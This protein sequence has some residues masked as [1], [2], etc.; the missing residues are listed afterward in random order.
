MKELLT[1]LLFLLEKRDRFK[2][3][4]LLTFILSGTLFELLGFGS[5]LPFLYVVSKPEL[6][7]ENVFLRNFYAWISPGSVNEFLVWLGLLIIVVFVLK[8]S[9]LY[10]IQVS[11]IKFSTRT[12]HKLASRLFRSYLYNPYSFHL[13]RNS[14]QLL[15]NIGIVQSIIT[16]ILLPL[17]NIITDSLLI[18]SL[19]IL[20]FI[21][22]GTSSLI[23]FCF[24]GFI[25]FLYFS[26][27]KNKLRSFGEEQKLHNEMLIRQFNQGLGSIKESK[28]LGREHFFDKSYS[29]H[30]AGLNRI[31]TWQQSI[32]ALPHFII[33][34]LM[35]TLI[36][37][38]MFIAIYKGNEI[39]T[40]LISLSFF[41]LAA[42]RLMPSLNKVNSAVSMIRFYIPGLEEV[43]SDLK[44]SEGFSQ[45]VPLEEKD[46][47]II[48][49]K[50]LE[51]QHISFTY[52]GTEKSALEDINLTIPKNSTVGFVGKSGAGKT[53]TVD[54]ILGLLNPTKGKVL[55]DGSDIHGEIKSW[56]RKAGHVPQQ[57]YLMD[58]TITA[59][60][61]FGI[62]D[63]E[64]NL[65]KELAI[66]QQ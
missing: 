59:N 2:V 60:I 30:L 62:L 17:I 44:M 16:G 35:V 12:H 42:V 63:D 25:S 24:V 22:D 48:F 7:S 14:A 13:Q 18:L 33:E 55:V 56:Q 37:F 41:G 46:S 36:L 54:I 27:F 10:L 15:R 45:S 9:Y 43:Y 65:M 64:V 39:S 6:V 23:V 20:L 52:D 1:K 5:I 29:D 28:I 53:T 4:L 34:T 40:I 51:L 61:A 66:P 32:S 47:H 50:E 21:V 57:I 58:D 11:V 38:T 3:V 26:I 49:H 8:N 31:A 19:F